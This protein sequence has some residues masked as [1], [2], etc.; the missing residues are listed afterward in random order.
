MVAEIRSGSDLSAEGFKVK[1]AI[2][3][4]S[5]GSDA[6]IHV[7]GVLDVTASGGGQVYVS[8]HPEIKNATL[9]GGSKLHEQ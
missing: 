1:Q 6:S 2:L 4:L 3:T 8:G 7:S 5:G 9:S